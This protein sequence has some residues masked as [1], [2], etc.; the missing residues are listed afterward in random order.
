MLVIVSVL[1]RLH[2]DIVVVVA[3]EYEVKVVEQNLVEA[4]EC[5]VGT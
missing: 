1:G 5:S 4:M 2:Y 3:M